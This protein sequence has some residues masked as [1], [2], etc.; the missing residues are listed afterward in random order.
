MHLQ[1]PSLPFTSSGLW[2]L[3]GITVDSTVSGG[4][5]TREWSYSYP[6]PKVSSQRC[7]PYTTPSG[8]RT[9]PKSQLFELHRL[10][11][12]FITHPCDCDHLCEGPQHSTLSFKQSK[13]IRHLGSRGL[14]FQRDQTTQCHCDWTVTAPHTQYDTHMTTLG[15]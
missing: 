15:L 9:S 12:H 6:G 14:G 10:I 5:Q 13:W 1:L 2:C 4:S 11:K 8:E 7:T 3:S